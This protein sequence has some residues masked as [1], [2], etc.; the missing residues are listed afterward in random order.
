MNLS[1]FSRTTVIAW[2]LAACVILCAIYATFAGVSADGVQGDLFATTGV[3][4]TE[5][6]FMAFGVVG[7]LIM[8]RQP[9]NSIGWLMILI[10]SV[11]LLQIIPTSE[12]V[13]QSTRAN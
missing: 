3:V 6:G 9:R 4:L 2:V 1:R 7:A 12:I 13:Q 8:A 5:V 10:S 11:T